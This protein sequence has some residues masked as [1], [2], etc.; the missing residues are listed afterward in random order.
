MTRKHSPGAHVCLTVTKRGGVATIMIN[1]PY[2]GNAI[3]AGVRKALQSASADLNADP[4]I[5]VVIL[6]GAGED[7]F[8]SGL[9]LPEL[10]SLPPD[11]VAALALD[12][13]RTCE[14]IQSIN[15][16]TM[17]A[18][19]GGCIGAALELALH[20]DIRVG[21]ADLRVGFPGVG[22]GLVPGAAGIE[23]LSRIAGLGPAQALYLTG[24]II[25]AERAF[26]LGI[27]TN[28]FGSSEFEAAAADFAGHL[29]QLP[30]VAAREL[31]DLLRVS[32][33]KGAIP[34]EAGAQALARCFSEGD[35]GERLRAM[36]EGPEPGTALH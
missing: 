11:G 21:R 34:P 22:I 27:I 23:R 8:S 33:A 14:A 6:T 13:R 15:A 32:A 9:D 12:M 17:A 3:D 4:D 25:S 5:R 29:A 24:G 30:A 28:V 35:A 1:R 31:K 36:F 10:A 18:L 20:C 26:M 19:K 2:A 16:V 7:G